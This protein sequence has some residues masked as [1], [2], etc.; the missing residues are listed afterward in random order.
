LDYIWEQLLSMLEHLLTTFENLRVMFDI[1]LKVEHGQY[2]VEDVLQAGIQGFDGF[3]AQTTFQCIEKP[4]EIKNLNQLR[5]EHSLG[6]PTSWKGH[7][8]SLQTCPW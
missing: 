8:Q 5:R 1:D 2:F 7:H 4:G 3:N 6:H